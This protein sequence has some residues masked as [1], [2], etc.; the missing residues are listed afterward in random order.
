MFFFVVPIKSTGETS[1]SREEKRDEG[2][3]E[4]RIWDHGSGR[5]GMAGQGRKQGSSGS[6]KLV[7]VI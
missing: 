6:D 4:S 2:F 1:Q 7:L 3:S 5:V